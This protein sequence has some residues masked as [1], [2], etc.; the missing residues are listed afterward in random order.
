[1]SDLTK[2]S[3]GLIVP[4]INWRKQDWA[5]EQMREWIILGELPSGAR[6]DQEQL[7]SQLGI[8]RIPLRE[9]IA[10]LTSEGLLHG[11]A[12]QQLVVSELSLED[13]RD[14]YCGR[15]ALEGALASQAAQHASPDD[16]IQIEDVLREQ[17]SHLG[18][19]G[20]DDFLKLDHRFHH[21]IY[22]TART[23]KTLNAAASL[24][25]MSQRYVRLYL[26]DP[27]RSV[28]S[29]REHTAIFAAIKLGDAETAS[30][31]TIEH[32]ATGLASLE[33]SYGERAD[34]STTRST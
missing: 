33:S 11:K 25:A 13:A 26:S 19:G 20:P 12:H 1:M 6:I 2:L 4:E 7:A 31:L 10:R 21:L 17:E 29:F 9:A 3:S 18:T 22:T 5:Y 24:F 28:T 32:V 34:G 8:S 30:R 16:L 14:V 23:P 15:Q 27:A